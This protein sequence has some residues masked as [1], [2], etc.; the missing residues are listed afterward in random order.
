MDFFPSKLPVLPNCAAFAPT[1][2][3]I[4]SARAAIAAAPRIA[5]PPMT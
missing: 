2:I 5:L 1:A 4:A 3:D